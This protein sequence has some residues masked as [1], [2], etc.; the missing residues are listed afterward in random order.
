M[1]QGDGVAFRYVPR[2]NERRSKRLRISEKP[3]MI[4]NWISKHS[5]VLLHALPIMA[6]TESCS[7]APLLRLRPSTPMSEQMT[8]LLACCR[9][10]VENSC[11][12]QHGPKSRIFIILRDLLYTSLV[13]IRRKK[14]QLYNLCNFGIN[15]IKT[16]VTPANGEGPLMWRTVGKVDRD[17]R[18]ST[19]KGHSH[20]AFSKISMVCLA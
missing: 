2:C 9:R 19:C 3:L 5:T 20:L 12:Y 1:L 4:S 7:M 11:C 17:T 13:Q 14:L 15:M 18:R 10:L 16:P 6:F 8:F